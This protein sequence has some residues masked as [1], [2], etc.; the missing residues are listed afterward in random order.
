MQHMELFISSLS[1]P[2]SLLID[3]LNC[4]DNVAALKLRVD[5]L[6]L[7]VVVF[8]DSCEVGLV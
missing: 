8:E 7:E 1:F 6:E 2:G 5:D 3:S 4:I